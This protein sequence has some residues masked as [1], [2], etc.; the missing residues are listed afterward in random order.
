[1]GLGATMFGMLKNINKDHC[2]L[3]TEVIEYFFFK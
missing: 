3:E 1:M 2:K